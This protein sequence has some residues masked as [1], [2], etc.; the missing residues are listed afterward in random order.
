MKMIYLKTILQE[1]EYG[2]GG[3]Q[4]TPE[5]SYKN[6]LLDRKKK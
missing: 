2:N 1:K 4:N 3:I 6:R 5:T